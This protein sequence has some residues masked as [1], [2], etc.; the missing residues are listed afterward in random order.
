MKKFN[1][2]NIKIPKSSHFIV[3]KEEIQFLA[4]EFYCSLFFDKEFKQYYK[5]LIDNAEKGK[6][7]RI[8]KNT[9]N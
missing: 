3:D 1:L 2:K 4:N 5:L 7:R 9:R 8:R 6:K